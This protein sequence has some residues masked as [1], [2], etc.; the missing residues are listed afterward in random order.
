[1]W[2]FVSPYRAGETGELVATLFEVVRLAPDFP[3]D[4]F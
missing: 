1:V 2:E 3:T 4:W